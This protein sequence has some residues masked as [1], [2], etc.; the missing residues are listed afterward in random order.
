MTN[1]KIIKGNF[2]QECTNSNA[3]ISIKVHVFL[4]LV[5][6]N[7][8]TEISNQLDHGHHVTSHFTELRFLA[9][10]RGHERHACVWTRLVN[11]SQVF[12]NKV[13]S[14]ASLVTFDWLGRGCKEQVLLSSK[15][16]SRSATYSGWS[17]G[18][19]HCLR[20]YLILI[21]LDIFLS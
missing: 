7:T 11:V 3:S 21:H 4:V 5:N 17:S 1:S 2:N 14:L 16:P 9:L 10:H 6:T 18:T 8:D 15:N 12:I 19:T 13:H 20:V